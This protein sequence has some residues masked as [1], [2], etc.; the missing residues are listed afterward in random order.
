MF[1]RGAKTKKKKKLFQCSGQEQDKRGM[2]KPG[3]TEEGERHGGGES[4]QR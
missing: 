1:G 2:K 3:D 4:P